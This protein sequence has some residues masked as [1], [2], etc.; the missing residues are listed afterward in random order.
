MDLN[1][2]YD[3]NFKRIEWSSH[4]IQVKFACPYIVAVLDN[5]LIEVRN[6]LNP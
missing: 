2:V 3:Y 1:G 4:V 6:I 5:G